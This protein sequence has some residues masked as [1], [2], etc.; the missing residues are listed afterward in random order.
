MK[1]IPDFVCSSVSVNT[2][3][4]V[5]PEPLQIKSNCGKLV[6]IPIPSSHIPV[7]SIQVRL[8]SSDRRDGMVSNF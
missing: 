7:N 1:K 3:I 8:L 6:D 5:P 4:K 2:E